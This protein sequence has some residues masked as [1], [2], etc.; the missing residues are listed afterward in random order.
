M[1]FT[2]AGDK[3]KT[4]LFGCDQK[5]SK[6]SKI[7]EALGSL[8]ELNSLLGILKVKSGEQNFS[9]EEK[10][11]SNIIHEVQQN[12]FIIQAELAGAQKKL[13]EHSVT[14]LEEIINAIEKALPPIKTFFI[15]GGTELA[16]LCDFSRTVTRSTERRVVEV[17]EESEATVGELTLP[18]LN[19]LSSLFY[20][21]ARLVNY[22][23]GIKEEPPSYN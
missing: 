2:G 8:D 23:S 9:F 7:A 3:G 6:S 15:S 20:A 22:K 12:L 11:F 18:Y 19:R 13:G 17:V 21:F 1:L 14:N 4:K 10:K 16:S 5:I